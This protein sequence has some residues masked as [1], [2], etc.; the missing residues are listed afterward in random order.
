[1]RFAYPVMLDV[2]DRLVVI[3]G[4]GAVAMRKVKTLLEAGAT[5]VRVVAPRMQS[6]MPMQVE[7][8]DGG[9]EPH[10]LD[11]AGLVFAATDSP[12]VN[13]QIVRDARARGVLV[14]RADDADEGDFVTP[15]RFQEGEVVVSVVAGSPALAVAIRNDLAQKLDPRHMKMAHAMQTLRPLI[16]DHVPADRRGA[17]LRD[18]ASDEA[19]EVVAR[20][21][22]A[23]LRS[24]IAG[25]YPELKL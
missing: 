22:E 3:I 5:R 19:I 8:I 4:G 21:D 20:G 15:A 1:V 13:E 7:R 14:S 9:Y 10:Y 11:G 23:A 12:A 16:R 24:W 17:I 2:T 25:K 6:D 18:L